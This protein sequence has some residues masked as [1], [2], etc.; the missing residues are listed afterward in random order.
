MKVAILFTGALRT[1]K[2]TMRYFKQNLLLNSD[3]DV[4]ACIQN[5]STISN[6]QW[7]E[8]IRLEM[9]DHLKSLEWF[10]PLNHP[11]WISIRDKMIS[12]LTITDHWKNYLRNSGSIIEY[13]QLYLAY[14][15]M[16]NY[17]DR[18]QR[19]N[20]IV[21]M[22]TD[23]IFAKPIDFH[24]LNWTDDEVSERIEKVN[25]E[26]SLSEIPITPENTLIYFMTT[27]ISDSLIPNIMNIRARY[28]PNQTPQIPLNPSELNKYVKSG[29]YILVTRANNLY[30][31]NRELFNFV[32]SLPFLYGFIKSPHNDEYWFNSE[33]QFQAACYFSGISVFDYNTRF[34]D[35]SL[36]EYDEKR[37][38]D[39]DYNILN[40]H[41]L[42]CLIRN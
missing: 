34:E 36:Y 37:Y 18:H 22:R 17:E 5:D 20:Y 10:S 4:F 31:V 41:M 40:P 19:Y 1:I 38:F 8:W 33:N 35:R 12:N 30:I 13:Y 39:L 7:E 21:R 42:Y 23:T 28:I 14:L 16:C 29:P 3:V 11:D 9:G 26:L 15:K 2:K 24:W 25:N 32:P 6:A 27:I